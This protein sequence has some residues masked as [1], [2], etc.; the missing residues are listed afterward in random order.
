M[1]KK[2]LTPLE[3]K[4][5]L[6]TFFIN[7]IENYIEKRWILEKLPEQFK[8]LDEIERGSNIH[9]LIRNNNLI[10]FERIE[11]E[12]RD[13]IDRKRKGI[14]EVIIF[15]EITDE[16]IEN[17]ILEAHEKSVKTKQSLN[18]SYFGQKSFNVINTIFSSEN[19]IKELSLVIKKKIKELLFECYE[20]VHDIN[21]ETKKLVSEHKDYLLYNKNSKDDNKNVKYKIFKNKIYNNISLQDCKN[22]RNSK[23]FELLFD[24]EN[25]NKLIHQFLKD[26]EVK[27]NKNE[28]EN[29]NSLNRFHTISDIPIKNRSKNLKNKPKNKRYNS[30]LQTPNSKREYLSKSKSNLINKQL[31]RPKTAS[32][33]V[34]TTISG[35]RN[36]S[37]NMTNYTLK[38]IKTPSALTIY[39]SISNNKSEN[40]KIDKLLS[41][42]IKDLFDNNQIN[43]LQKMNIYDDID[44]IG[45]IFDYSKLMELRNTKLNSKTSIKYPPFVMSKNLL[46][47]G[48]LFDFTVANSNKKS[49]DFRIS[50]IKK[51]KEKNFIKFQNI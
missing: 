44:N 22:D 47:S 21:K 38:R 19:E 13:K 15:K 12:R 34:E 40:K 28:D 10:E 35:Y 27:N 26:N 18:P 37:N 30:N 49:K 50:N 29:I 23:V 24:F 36:Y 3:E 16:D 48:S 33:R 17:E 51:K 43:I 14:R 8:F 11:Q 25:N 1:R 5:E 7:D 32:S 2:K 42:N 20:N 31:L 39:P 46:N 6:F 45:R 41:D 4:F 9:K